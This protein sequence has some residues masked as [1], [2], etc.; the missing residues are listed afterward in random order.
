MAQVMERQDAGWLPRVPSRPRS[1]RC[2]RAL[3][4]LALACTLSACAVPIRVT[5]LDTQTVHRE[6]SR[7]ALSAGEPSAFTRIILN[8]AGLFERFQE[9]PES[10]LRTLHGE[11]GAGRQD[12]AGVLFALA[13]LSFLYAGGDGPWEIRRAHYLAAAVY[14]YAFLFPP[15]DRL[16]SEPYDPRFRDACDLYN[17]ALTKALLAPDGK[18]AQFS[19]GTL[20]LPF[21]TLEVAFDAAQLAWLD[22]RLTD[23][24]PLADVEVKGLRD[25]YRRPGI[26]APFAAAARGTSAQAG[27]QVA[28]QLRTPVTA[29][30]RIEHPQEGM[31]SGR[32]QARLE[33]HA[34]SDVQTVQVG[35]RTVPLEAEP[36]AA[37]ALMLGESD[38]WDFELGGFLLGDLLPR[39]ATE[40][41]LFALQPYRPGR[42]PVVFVHGTAS[43]PARWAE[44]FNELQNDPR[45][46]RR[47]QFWFFV[48]ETG[49]PIIFSA[50]RLREALGRALA[51]IDPA[52]GDP[53][54][55]RM[56]IIGH[57]QGGLLTKLMVVDLE[58]QVR[59][60][61]Y[62]DDAGAQQLSAETREL[63]QGVSAIRPLPFVR[64]VIFLATPHR[65]SYVAG[66]W[67]AHQL[68]RLV[69]L[70]GSV[71]Q[72][73]G[74]LLT[75]NPQLAQQVGG[76]IGS[77]S[78]MTPGSPLVAILAP[79]P[80]APWVAGHSIIAVKGDGP[81][82][83][84][85]DGVVAY[86][87]AHLEGMASELVVRSGHSV[88]Q[89]AAGI[90]EVRRI[91]LEHAG[92]E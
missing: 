22:R 75:A 2:R 20:P 57:S 23:A 21:G 44:M 26:G 86:P 8:R 13:E 70:P 49:N 51:S 10:V 29:F 45:I 56:V 19:G 73:A 89:S 33:L 48:Y 78:A 38:L 40:T 71:L 30:L 12:A 31:A 28:M 37:L 68:A 54:L 32:I 62:P 80:L 16:A 63:L 87:S 76:Q 3:L 7:N 25:R 47:Y 83:Q 60:M 67:L 61:M 82:E 34:T 46:D 52:G 69:R 64:R 50:M 53:A 81:R 88:Q 59:A 5:P 4:A 91:L 27:L 18:T 77:V 39:Q 11:V 36:T 1:I 66:N 6:L 79:A 35:A 92:P 17:R 84:E 14:A 55:Q 43:S 72:G 24:I 90:E 74:D 42:I 58:A 15:S 9:Q 85:T 65:G 41:Q